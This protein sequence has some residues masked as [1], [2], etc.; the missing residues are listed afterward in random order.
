MK[1]VRE[2]AAFRTSEAATPNA[3]RG[4]SGARPDSGTQA[5][6]LMSLK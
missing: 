4:P 2:T 3:D 5:A 6:S 1:G